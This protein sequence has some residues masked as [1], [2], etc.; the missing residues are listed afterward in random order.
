ME[1]GTK[2]RVAK[3]IGIKIRRINWEGADEYV[4]LYSAELNSLLNVSTRK[5]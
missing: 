2:L 5:S 4:A 3:N 1:A